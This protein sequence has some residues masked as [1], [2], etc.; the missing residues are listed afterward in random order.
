MKCSS[1]SV[2]TSSL[3]QIII[4]CWV[5]VE[6]FL[7]ISSQPGVKPTHAPLRLRW[8]SFRNVALAISWNVRERKI[9][10]VL[11]AA[12]RLLRGLPESVWQ[13]LMNCTVVRHEIFGLY[14]RLFGFWNHYVCVWHQLQSSHLP[15]IQGLNFFSIHCYDLLATG[16]PCANRRQTG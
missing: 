13:R 1:F 10:W 14:V 4:L 11:S 8:G 7:V 9:C 15:V 5:Y 3:I 2:T 16:P 12:V 6:L